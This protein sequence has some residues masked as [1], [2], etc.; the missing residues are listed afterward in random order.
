MKRL[1]ILLTI[2]IFLVVGCATGV[3]GTSTTIRMEGKKGVYQ[4][5]GGAKELYNPKTNMVWTCY[6][7]Y[8]YD[9]DLNLVGEE[10]RCTSKKLYKVR[11]LTRKEKL[12]LWYYNTFGETIGYSDPYIN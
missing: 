9:K 3:N 1:F 4:F 6:T 2:A 11:G 10:L 5:S 12:E 8:H 7:S